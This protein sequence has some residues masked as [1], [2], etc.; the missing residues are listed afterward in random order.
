M[1][2]GKAK[3]L[4]KLNLKSI[5]NIKH[6]KIINSIAGKLIIC[7]L[8]PVLF[9]IIL[10]ISAYLNASRTII[11]NYTDA[12][13]SAINSTGQY[14]NVILQSVEDQATQIVN[15]NTIKNYYSSF[16]S[17]DAFKEDEYRKYVTNTVTGLSVTGRYI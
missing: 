15:D 8:L 11:D 4:K 1:K 7:F 16:D 5:K 12:T 10:G 2:I 3:K 14:Y 17:L 6:I 9:L 13:V